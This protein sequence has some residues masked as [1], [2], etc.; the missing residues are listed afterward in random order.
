LYWLSYATPL[1]RPCIYVFAALLLIALWGRDRLSFALFASGVLYELSFFPA[2]AE[3]DYR[4]S[5]WM[6]TSSVIACVIVLIQ[7]RR[8][9]EAATS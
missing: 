1:F 6:I 2:F 8:R 5:H 7:R 9:R 3:S 4:Y